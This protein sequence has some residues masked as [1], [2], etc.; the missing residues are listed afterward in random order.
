MRDEWIW[1]RGGRYREREVR[2]GALY[3]CQEA[4][5]SSFHAV[6]Q[7]MRCSKQKNS[8]LV[9]LMHV[10]FLLR[11]AELPRSVGFEC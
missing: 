8:A 9:A 7:G 3:P 10:T 1:D 6:Q 4:I 5:R 2:V 11:A